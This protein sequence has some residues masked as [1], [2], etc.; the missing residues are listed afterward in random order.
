MSK[1][2]LIVTASIGLGHNKAAEAMEKVFREKYSDYTIKIT[3]LF[4]HSSFLHRALY[5]KTYVEIVK[6]LPYLYR[7]LYKNFDRAGSIK[8]PIVI[9][10]RLNALS[11]VKLVKSFN[12]SIVVATHFIP[13]ALINFLRRKEGLDCQVYYVI[14]D[15]EAHYFWVNS[16]VNMYF[17]SHDEVRFQLNYRG[18]PNSKIKVTGIPVKPE[19]L[20]RKNLRTLRKKY[21]LFEKPTLLMVAGSAGTLPSLEILRFIRKIKK[22]FQ[23]IIV[24]G[25]DLKLYKKLLEYQRKDRRIRKVFGFVDFIEDLMAVSDIII[26]KPGGLTVSESLASGLPM[27]A[28]NPIPGQEEANVNYLQENGAA[29]KATSLESLVYKVDN[30][31]SNRTELNRMKEN[32][33]RIS[34]PRAALNIVREIIRNL[35]D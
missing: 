33:K 35:E 26:S 18:I 27:V 6:K 31:I 4:D 25:S 28:F 23:I 14:T 13:G 30:L 5:D 10:D 16:D 3:D 20:K 21:N 17:V 15:Y 8:M 1:K 34:R 7:Y 24:C 9:F 12:P 2:I 22:D 29:L 32:V 11:F 19:F